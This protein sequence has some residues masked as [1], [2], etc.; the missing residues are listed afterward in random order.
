MPQWLPKVGLQL[1]LAEGMETLTWY[2]RGP[3][4]TYP[5]R[6]T[7]ARVGIH[8]GSV[9]DQDVPYIVPQDHGNKTDVRWA[10]LRSAQGVGLFVS[11]DALLNLS[12]P[13]LNVAERGEGGSG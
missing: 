8:E 2:G 5:D 9:T 10:A 13:I 6:K 7:G 1:V 3:H 11:G 12:L 4:E